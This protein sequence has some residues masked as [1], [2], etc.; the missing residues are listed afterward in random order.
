MEIQFRATDT[1]GKTWQGE[2]LEGKEAKHGKIG[3]GVFDKFMK[4][5]FTESFFKHIKFPGVSDVANE[6]RKTGGGVLARRLK[7]MVDKGGTMEHCSDLDDVPLDDIVSMGPKWMFSKFL[8]LKMGEKIMKERNN[9]KEFMTLIFR[10][11]TSQSELSGPFYK[12][13]SK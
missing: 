1:Q 9:S 12:V 13:T 5:I 10:Y 6:S 2:V 4:E 11:A 7:E 8:G 3:G